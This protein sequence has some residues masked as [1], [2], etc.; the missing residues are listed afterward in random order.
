MTMKVSD[1]EAIEHAPAP[2]SGVSFT[3][4]PHTGCYV[5]TRI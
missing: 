2:G 3:L 1:I 4:P 5:W